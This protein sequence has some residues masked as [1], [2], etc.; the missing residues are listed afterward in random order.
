MSDYIELSKRS[1]ADLDALALTAEATNDYV[2][3]TRV[4][5]AISRRSLV[6]GGRRAAAVDSAMKEAGKAIDELRGSAARHK[7]NEAYLLL[8]EARIEAARDDEAEEIGRRRMNAELDA[9]IAEL[10]ARAEA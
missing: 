2:L 9:R 10:D 8:L 1:F 3:R 4:Q 6:Y 7:A 5:Q